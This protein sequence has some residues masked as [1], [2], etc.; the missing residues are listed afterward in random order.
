[1]E[2]NA[3]ENMEDYTVLEEGNINQQHHE[4]LQN[5]TNFKTVFLPMEQELKK[6]SS[7]LFYYQ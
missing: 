6:L 4:I 1:M 5:S 3:K 7:L 2:F